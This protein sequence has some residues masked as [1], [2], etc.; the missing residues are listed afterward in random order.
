MPPAEVP[1]GFQVWKLP[2]WVGQAKLLE[3][4]P[5]KGATGPLCLSSHCDMGSLVV[6]PPQMEAGLMVAAL[7]SVALSEVHSGH[8]RSS[9]SPCSHLC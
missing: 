4:L 2:V 8:R 1:L 3:G 5:R 7:G 6:L 9:A